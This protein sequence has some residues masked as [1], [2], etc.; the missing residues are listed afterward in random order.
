VKFF[1]SS[2]PGEVISTRHKSNA[3]TP[4]YAEQLA[5][6]GKMFDSWSE[7]EQVQFVQTL[8]TRMCHH[9]HGQIDEFLKP[10]LQRNFISS[11]PGK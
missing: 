10:M 7:T 5:L 3:E 11:L 4:E 2:F 6:C 9:Q 1:G 8:L